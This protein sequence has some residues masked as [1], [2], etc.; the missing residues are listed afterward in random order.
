MHG[1]ALKELPD[2]DS[3]ELDEWDDWL[4]GAVVPEEWVPPYQPEAAMW[5]KVLLFGIKDALGMFG[6]VNK[7]A[8]I[9]W[10][11]N[12]ESRKVGSVLWICDVLGIESIERLRAATLGVSAKELSRMKARFKVM[13]YERKSVK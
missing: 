3:C 4:L 8:A 2:P 10:L 13:F 5:G 11:M 7:G 6:P 9:E 1:C 12:D